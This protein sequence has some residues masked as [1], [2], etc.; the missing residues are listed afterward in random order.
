MKLREIQMR[1]PFVVPVAEEGFYYLYGTTDKDCNAERATGFDVY[2]SRDLKDWEGPFPA[3][4]PEAGFWAVKNFWAPEV[5]PYQGRYYMFASFKRDGV[6]RGTQVLA[7]DHPLG[8]FRPHSEGP[9]TPLNWECLDGTLYLD[10]AGDPWMVFCHEW[11]QIMDGSFCAMRLTADLTAAVG[12]PQLLF[13]ASEAAWCRP[14][15]PIQGQKTHVSDGPFFYRTSEGGLLM[16]WSS[17]G[18][19]GYAIALSV[20]D[21]G[22][23]LGPWRHLEAPLYAKDGGHG[24]VFRRFDGTLM[25]AIHCPND[26][27]NE[28]PLF[29]EIE[30]K[31][32]ILVL[33]NEEGRE[34]EKDG[35]HP[36]NAKIEGI[37]CVRLFV[38]DLEAGL[39][40]Y[41]QALGLPI[42]WKKEDSAGLK[43]GPGKA[44]LVI[45]TKDRWFEVDLMVESVPAALTVV[46]NA[47][48]TVVV[49]PFDIDI[50]KA[51]VVKDP[52]DNSFV[53]LDMSKG[54]YLTDEQGNILGQNDI[55]A[56]Q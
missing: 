19:Q 34:L 40:Y 52:W 4:R 5:Y 37:D 21:T 30:E 43:L 12:K 31:D 20:S 1:D 22:S 28:R 50:G 42:L 48:G 10:E 6:S 23:V 3:F 32:G 46:K 39:A 17:Y 47:G 2:R 35:S 16:L 26:T 45:Q 33:K 38:E 11:V 27:P 15:M 14:Y 44:E 49:E 7:A 9:V 54:S 29:L 18:E 53:L 24:M 8:P 51:A 41:H 56:D 13:H 55:K 25:L 36:M